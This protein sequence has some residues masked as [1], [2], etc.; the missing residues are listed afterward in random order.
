MIKIKLI[1]LAAFIVAIGV[2]VYRNHQTD[3]TNTV[4]T[5]KTTSKSLSSA[6]SKA[7]QASKPAVNMCADNSKTKAII[8]SIN[9]QHL[10]SCS[11]TEVVYQTAVTT[12][13]VKLGDGTPT[14][15]WR[16]YAKQ[17]NR[18]LY[19][20]DS[21]GSWN[22]YVNYWMPYDGDFGFHDATWQTLTFGSA[23]YTSKGS[24][25][26]VRLPLTAMK[27]LYNW[28]PIGTTVTIEA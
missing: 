26:C 25:G 17:P 11:R 1:V 19:G 8:V 7:K 12:G 22:D 27:W 2:F 20:S 14:G 13:A 23:E 6:A 18:Y 24:H 9:Q 10:W 4:A 16:V 3:V 5:V 21:R 28:A 15:T